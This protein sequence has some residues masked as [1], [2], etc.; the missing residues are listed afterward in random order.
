MALDRALILLIGMAWKS[1]FRPKLFRN[2]I[3]NGMLTN[4]LCRPL[5]VHES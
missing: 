2:E 4:L 3:Q 1:T 5:A